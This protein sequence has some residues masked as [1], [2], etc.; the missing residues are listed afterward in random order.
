MSKFLSR[1]GRRLTA[2]Y[3]M[4]YEISRSLVYVCKQRKIAKAINQKREDTLFRGSH[5]P[6][7][8]YIEPQN[9]VKIFWNVNKAKN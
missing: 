6:K 4:K 5:I 2:N 3:K 1:K 9:T 8:P 7:K